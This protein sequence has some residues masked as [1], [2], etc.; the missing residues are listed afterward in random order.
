[1]EEKKGEKEGEEEKLEEGIRG[2]RNGRMEKDWGDEWRRTN[3][4]LF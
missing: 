3:S 1:M 2:A 4:R